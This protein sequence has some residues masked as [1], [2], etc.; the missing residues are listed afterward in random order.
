MESISP[1]CYIDELKKQFIEYNTDSQQQS[2]LQEEIAKTLKPDL[3]KPQYRD[4]IA[5]Y[6]D[7]FNKAVR[8]L[9]E[10]DKHNLVLYFKQ[11]LTSALRGVVDAQI[12]VM[13]DAE[14]SRI[15]LNKIQQLALNLSANSE[16][17]WDELRR[18]YN[19][20]SGVRVHSITSSYTNSDSNQAT[21]SSNNSDTAH[22]PVNAVYQQRTQKRARYGTTLLQQLL[23]Q[24]CIKNNLCTWCHNPRHDWVNGRCNKTRIR[25]DDDTIE[26]FRLSQLYNQQTATP[27]FQQQQHLNMRGR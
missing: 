10:S 24:Y 2:R 19:K 6:I 7:K 21:S 4:A 18:R 9:D 20:R 15:D 8:E 13:N 16:A 25:I 11:Q 22:I 27:S 17:S 14:R 3:T 26:K 12:N 23:R 1:R 5:D